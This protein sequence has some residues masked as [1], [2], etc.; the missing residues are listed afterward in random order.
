MARYKSRNKASEEI[1]HWVHISS[2]YNYEKIKSCGLSHPV[3][4]PLL[5]LFQETNTQAFS[6]HQAFQ[7]NHNSRDIWTMGHLRIIFRKR[8]EQM[9]YVLN[10]TLRNVKWN[11]RI[12]NAIYLP[13]FE[14]LP[15][16][17][18]PY[19]IVSS[20]LRININLPSRSCYQRSCTTWVIGLDSFVV[21]LN[22]SPDCLLWSVD[23]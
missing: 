18:P 5:W 9:H 2:L 8:E 3:C 21:T 17:G 19:S 13:I 6:G 20:S 22:L 12:K 14:M 23:H 4:G 1:N 11:S 7:T 10:L 15:R 16:H